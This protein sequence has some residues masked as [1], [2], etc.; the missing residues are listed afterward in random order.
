MEGS[1]LPEYSYIQDALEED[2]EY[3]LRFDV[4]GQHACRASGL[5]R[6]QEPRRGYPKTREELLAYDVIICSDIARGAF[7]PG[8]SSGRSSWSASAAAVSS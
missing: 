8:S 5:H 1:P 7:T 2:S 6:N 3:H 4:H